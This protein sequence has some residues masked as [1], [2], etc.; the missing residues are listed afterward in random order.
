MYSSRLCEGRVCVFFSFR[1]GFLILSI[2]VLIF[3]D[4]HLLR[5]LGARHEVSLLSFAFDTAQPQNSAVL[6]SFCS[7][8][9]T[10]D[11]NPFQRQAARSALRFLSTDPVVTLPLPEVT[12]TVDRLYQQT[13]F[14]AVIS[15][16]EV[17]VRLRVAGA[18]FG[19]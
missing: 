18:T 19:R 12:A 8:I 1:P 9:E 2:T 7:T 4:Y 17:M 14:D 15:S 11:R 13:A 5:A 6:A 3:C 16:V 10:V